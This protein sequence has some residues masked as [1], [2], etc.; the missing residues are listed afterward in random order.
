MAKQLP[1]GEYAF[2]PNGSHLAMY[3]DQQNYFKALIGFLKKQ[4]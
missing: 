3:D 4:E 1:H 2:M